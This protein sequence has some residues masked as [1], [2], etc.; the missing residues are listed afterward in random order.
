MKPRHRKHLGDKMKLHLRV[1]TLGRKTYNIISL[2]PETQITFSNNRF[3]ETW[4]LLSCPQGA[5][6]LAHLLWGLS[7][8]QKPNTFILLH[9][10]HIETTPFE[11]AR[12]LPII[13]APHHLTVPNR[14]ML[15][16][17]NKQHKHLGP[18]DK[19][20]RWK[21]HGLHLETDKAW[22]SERI[23]WSAYPWTRERMYVQSG[24]LVYVAPPD[25][26]RLRGEQ[27]KNTHCPRPWEMDYFYV[28]EGDRGHEWPE[29][30][31]QFFA[32]YKRKCSIARQARRDVIERCSMDPPQDQQQ[33]IWK[34]AEAI[35]QRLQPKTT[36]DNIPNP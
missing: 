25:I 23:P 28:A 9:D 3:H 14:D 13:L 30:E 35:T 18:S 31:F 32:Q 29:G 8:Q 22:K 33:A 36:D 19:T 20:I 10:Q 7:Y 17:L 4:H 16:A 21:S 24:F 26:L 34:Q 1:R 5:K 6:L 11:A 2:R 15:A 12:S 27:L